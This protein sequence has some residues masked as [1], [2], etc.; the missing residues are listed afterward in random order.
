MLG[1][2][3][4]RWIDLPL[5]RTHVIDVGTGPATMLIPGLAGNT[6]VWDEL[7]PGLADLGRTVLI[8]LWGR[9][10]SDR[11]EGPHYD[12]DAYVAQVEAV[13]AALGLERMAVVGSSMGGLVAAAYAARYPGHVSAAALMAPAGMPQAHPALLKLVEVPGLGDYAMSIATP[14]WL[15]VSYRKMFF[16]DALADRRFRERFGMSATIAG[17][18]QAI[19]QTLRTL[20]LGAAPGFLPAL[21]K[22][23][24]P[25]LVVWGDEDE[26]LQP[27]ALDAWKRA[28]PEAR[29]LKVARTG[30]LPH[31]EAPAIVG[32][33][34]RTFLRESRDVT[35]PTAQPVTD[36]SR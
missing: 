5:G 35:S 29:T 24:V 7:R 11:P 14:V 28:L 25:V 15:R 1:D 9:G 13:R 31:A 10:L 3:D 12:L 22:A 6:T 18:R 33:T 16:N 19:L 21:A 26:I 30:H 2:P 17:F 8:D 27:V 20:D 4:S 34:V 32:P 36:P 23:G